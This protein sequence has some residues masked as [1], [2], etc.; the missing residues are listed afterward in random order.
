MSSLAALGAIWRTLENE[1]ER[2]LHL[3]RVAGEH[4]VPLLE[5]GILRLQERARGLVGRQLHGVDQAW[6]ELRMIEQIRRIGAQLDNLV[7]RHVEPFADREVDVVDARLLQGI[8]QAVETAL[9]PGF[10]R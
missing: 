7:L 5:G 9:D 3:P 4:L 2:Q 6:C 8:A 10:T 1:L